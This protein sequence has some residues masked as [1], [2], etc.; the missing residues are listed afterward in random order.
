MLTDT[1]CRTGISVWP[2]DLIAMAKE[3]TKSQDLLEIS[4]LEKPQKLLWPLHIELVILWQ[5][6][7]WANCAVSAEAGGQVSFPP[8]PGREQPLLRGTNAADG[9]KANAQQ[10]T[11]APSLPRWQPTGLHHCF[12]HTSRAYSLT[13]NRAVPFKVAKVIVLFSACSRNIKGFVM[14]LLNIK[15]KEIKTTSLLVQ[16][17]Q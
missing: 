8:P 13:V 16:V 3:R 15:N 9:E 17:H 10:S 12:V 11:M 7:S 6:I 1:L 4:L 14:I 5:F 2:G